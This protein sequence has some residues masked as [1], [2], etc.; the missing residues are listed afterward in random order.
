ML[1]PE[2]RYKVDARIGFANRHDHARTGDY[3]AGG[4]YF[5]EHKLF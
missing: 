4:I 1:R 2:A 5:D 3:L